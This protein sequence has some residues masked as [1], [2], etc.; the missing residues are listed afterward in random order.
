MSEDL[1]ES[2]LILAS[3]VARARLADMIFK[4]TN[5]EQDVLEVCLAHHMGK[6]KAL[7]LRASVESV[8]GAP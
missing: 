5:E 8:L 6:D 1:S 4:E 2:E 3:E 7:T